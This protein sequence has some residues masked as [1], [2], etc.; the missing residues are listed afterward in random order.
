MPSMYPEQA[1]RNI[2]NENTTTTLTT[3]NENPT[4]TSMTI[5]D[6]LDNLSD[7]SEDE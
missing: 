4:T 7:I 5:N 1:S 3:V 2:I 6:Y